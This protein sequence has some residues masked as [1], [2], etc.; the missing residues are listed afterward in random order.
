MEFDVAEGFWLG[1]DVVLPGTGLVTGLAA[2][3]GG[4]TIVGFGAD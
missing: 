1:A 3:L 4:L 2:V